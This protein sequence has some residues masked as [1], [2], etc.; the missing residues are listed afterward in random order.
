MYVPVGTAA[1]GGGYR[2][3]ANGPTR[4]W[5]RHEA[6]AEARAKT[7]ARTKVAT[8]RRQTEAWATTE[9]GATINSKLGL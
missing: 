2:L 7:E 6:E 9:R 1:T 3:K 8:M 4:A 5:L